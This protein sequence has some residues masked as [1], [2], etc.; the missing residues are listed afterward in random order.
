MNIA[1]RLR[2]GNRNLNRRLDRILH[3]HTSRI[4]DDARR[5]PRPNELAIACRLAREVVRSHQRLAKEMPEYFDFAAIDR[6]RRDAE[7]ERRFHE[8][9]NPILDKIYQPTPPPPL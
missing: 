5:P 1:N 4:V 8:F 9:L 2:T 7:R 6:A 3:R